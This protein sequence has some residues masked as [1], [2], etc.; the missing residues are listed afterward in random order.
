[1]DDLDSFVG[2]IFFFIKEVFVDF[3]VQIILVVKSPL[4]DFI[5][6][7]L[8]NF[9]VQL[10]LWVFLELNHEII[11]PCLLFLKFFGQNINFFVHKLAFVEFLH[12]LL[13]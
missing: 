11:Q 9:L 2:F 5:S 3:W 1:M 13:L 8:N 7:T 12:K 4:S 10:F 6:E